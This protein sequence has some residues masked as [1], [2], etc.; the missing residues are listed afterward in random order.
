MNESDSSLFSVYLEQMGYLPTDNVDEADI[1]IVNTCSV[2]QHAEE[3]AFAEIGDLKHYKAKNP[4]GK[5]V[6]VGCMAERMK[7]EL[8]QKFP[9]IDLLIGAMDV[10]RFPDMMKRAGVVSMQSSA[11]RLQ[12]KDDG[13]GTINTKDGI[14]TPPGAARNDNNGAD[15]SATTENPITTYI[16]ITRGCNNFCSYC[17]VPYV[18]GPE[19]Y[20]A[21]EEIVKEI[22]QLVENGLREVILLGQNVNSYRSVMSIQDPLSYTYSL[23][24]ADFSDLLTLINKIPSLK[25]IRFMTNHPKD[26][27]DKF[28][29]TMSTLNKVCNHI[30]L[31]LQ[32]GSDRILGLMNRKYT[33]DYYYGLIKKL[34]YHIADISITTDLMVGFPGETDKDFKQTL[35]AVNKIKFDFAYV[36]KYSP[37]EK[38]EA[39]KLGDDVKK[40]VKEKRH[41]ELLDLC[42][43][44][45][46]EKNS[47]YT[48][49]LAEV[50]IESRNIDP[51][52]PGITNVYVGKTK[53]N[54]AVTFESGRNL[55]GQPF[56][57]KIKEA[58]VHSLIGEPIP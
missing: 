48:G 31:P 3:R 5:V 17:V 57:I 53:D 8:K 1:A 45:A 35:E 50:L 19:E 29:K 38:T 6:V 24:E 55:I 25:R 13:A 42:N 44:V 32:S 52:N 54:R 40:E 14:A 2:R 26:V 30:H 21:V 37:R 20:R 18:R 41:K 7:V 15:K 16:T 34:R 27:T 4:A 51:D 39:F 22:T 49:K 11:L 43:A 23:K 47:K 28:I 10:E 58:K 46:K 12:K 56:N 9:Q 33:M 36:F